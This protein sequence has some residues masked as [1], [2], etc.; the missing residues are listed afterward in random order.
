MAEKLLAIG[1][2]VL[3]CLGMLALRLWGEL[4]RRRPGA[5]DPDVVQR[6]W[7]HIYRGDHRD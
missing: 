6:W 1:L 2:V 7:A 5:G 3:I 4:R